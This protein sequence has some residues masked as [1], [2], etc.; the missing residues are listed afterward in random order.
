FASLRM[1][2]SRWLAAYFAVAIAA[3]LRVAATPRVFSAVIDEPVH[4]VAGQEWWLG[5]VAFDPS[6]PPLEKLL[7]A[8]PYRHRERID[9][10]DRLSRGLFLLYDAPDDI[11]NLARARL[12]N[13]MFLA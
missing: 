9:V 10:P 5:E 6:H 12:P 13:L 8:I 7:S 2:K 3:L 11:R 1:T 4:I